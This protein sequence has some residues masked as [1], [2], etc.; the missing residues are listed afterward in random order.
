VRRLSLTL[1]L[2]LL[3]PLSTLAQAVRFQSQVIGS[4]GLPLG[5]QSVAVCTQPAN[6]NTTPCSP[7]ATLATSAIT[8]SGGANP[9][10]TDVNGNFFFYLPANTGKVTIQIFGPQ[11]ATPFVQPDVV[12]PADLSQNLTFT[13]VN[14]L[15][16]INS[17]VVCD[18]NKYITIQA[19]AAALPAT[20]GE[21]EVPSASACTWNGVGF[22]GNVTIR[23]MNA[24]AT[25]AVTAPVV[26]TNGNNH[27]I[28]AGP[29]SVG[30]SGQN[31][32]F[33][34]PNTGTILNF[35]GSL[36]GS[37][38]AITSTG[39]DANSVENC[40]VQMGV[41]LTSQ[42]GRAVIRLSGSNGNLIKG[43][44]FVNA[45][46]YCVW[47][48]NGATG[49]HS[50][51]N[52]IE[53]NDCIHAGSD[54]WRLSEEGSGAG[55]TDRTTFINDDVHP[56]EN[57]G[58]TS[59][60]QCI[61][62]FVP[63]T[64]ASTNIVTNTK[65]QNVLCNGTANGTPG[66]TLENAKT[67]LTTAM[68]ADVVFEKAEIEDVYQTNTA[69]AVK[70]IDTAPTDI[71]LIDLNGGL[72][73]PGYTTTTNANTSAPSCAANCTFVNGYTIVNGV[74]S[75]NTNVPRQF[76]TISFLNNYSATASCSS[77]AGASF[78]SPGIR[79]GTSAP[80]SSLLYTSDNILHYFRCDTGVDQ[81]KVDLGN[82]QILPSTSNTWKLGNHSVSA[83]TE[84]SGF[85]Y[86]WPETVAPTAAAINEV[87]YGDSTA[88]ALKCSYNN[89]TFL[90]IPQVIASGTSTLNSGALAATTCQATVT[91]AAIGAAA[92][93]AIGWSFATVPAAA[94][95]LTIVSSAPT[96]N[97]VNF[98]RCNPTAASQT[99]TAIV[100][101]W[102]VVR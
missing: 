82:T 73:G 29:Q 54:G 17:R 32:G 3:A 78:A 33:G 1:S 80:S 75:S 57:G 40:Y 77:S 7:L 71:A 6:T 12:V 93:D 67:G 19:A 61:H 9:T 2:L 65:F 51:G 36:T 64:A 18:G 50:Y 100:I 38:D 98:V 87:C 68:I 91:T 21:V 96:A 28:C 76:D 85:A 41:P 94:D 52:R 30:L 13:G 95:G 59:T 35:N 49:F 37:Q 63:S 34:N 10:T 42:G 60:G 97:N 88:H 84:I 92:T 74:P 72:V 86:F 43:N 26:M 45:G 44:V 89:G 11:V 58:T 22:T 16:N 46:S 20:G 31:T 99:T 66:M 5:G 25:Y 90:N 79:F 23:F 4:R 15:S 69:T 102:R 53:S 24:K 39:N 14:T 70:I 101:N 27:L 81:W 56:R 8:N 47:I 83:W 55:D 48:D 62:I